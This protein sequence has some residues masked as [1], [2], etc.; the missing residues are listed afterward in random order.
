MTDGPEAVTGIQI[1]NQE[2]VL[3]IA[4][5][6]NGEF[7]KGS[8][9]K[10]EGTQLYANFKERWFFRGP[11]GVKY[12]IQKGDPNNLR[13]ETHTIDGQES[14]YNVKLR[15]WET[16]KDD[17]EASARCYKLLVDDLGKEH[18]VVETSSEQPDHDPDT[19][20]NTWDL[21]ETRS[22]DEADISLLLLRMTELSR[23]DQ[24]RK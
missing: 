12:D 16:S 7:K 10:L 6:S 11:D 21:G 19:G 24:S 18:W 5:A 8:N 15:I 13:R 9:T 2:R 23:S 3:S 1:S 14:D 22:A 20:I 4:Q 17:N